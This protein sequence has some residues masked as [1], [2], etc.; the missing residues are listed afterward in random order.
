MSRKS[1]K[2]SIETYSNTG[3]PFGGHLLFY[4][5]ADFYG[6]SEN[7]FNFTHEETHICSVSITSP[8]ARSTITINDSPDPNAV[9]S[10]SLRNRPVGVNGPGGNNNVFYTSEA[11]VYLDE[12]KLPLV[13]S[14]FDPNNPKVAY[15]DTPLIGDFIGPGFNNGQ[16]AIYK[17]RFVRVALSP[18]SYGSWA[19]GA[20]TLPNGRCAVTVKSLFVKDDSRPSYPTDTYLRLQKLGPDGKYI[21]VVPRNALKLGNAVDSEGFCVYVLD[22]LDPD[23]YYSVHVSDITPY[24]NDSSAVRNYKV[25]IKESFASGDT[26]SIFFWANN[27]LDYAVR[28]TTFWTPAPNTSDEDVRF[29]HESCFAGTL[30]GFKNAHKYD[31]K[32]NVLNGDTYYQDNSNAG[33][34]FI[35]HYKSLLRNDNTWLTLVSKGSYVLRDDHEVKDNYGNNIVLTNGNTS[36]FQLNA[37]EN[38]LYNATFAS[39]TTA[40][41]NIYRRINQFPLGIVPNQRIVD[42]FKEFDQMWPARPAYLNTNDS[43]KVTWGKLETIFIN[44]SPFLNPDNLAV[45]YWNRRAI[46]SYPGT[47]ANDINY[48]N[49]APEFIPGPSLAFLKNALLASK[50]KNTMARAVFFSSDIKLTFNGLYD[51]VRAKFAQLA[52][53]ADPSASESLINTTYDK[54]FKAFNYADAEGYF[55]QI[56][57]LVEW[58]KENDIKNVFFFTG[59]PHVS[60]VSYMDRKYNIDSCCCS[61]IA[62]YRASGFPLMFYGNK[63][64]DEVILTVARNSYAD[65]TFSPKNKNMNIKFRYADEIRGETNISLIPN[66][67]P[68]HKCHGLLRPIDLLLGDD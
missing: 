45:E 62:T 3:A 35:R 17:C 4:N 50:N 8:L 52:R 19:G 36:E 41:F 29:M 47:S 13:I 66:H 21:D 48:L 24:T 57:E 22:D 18:T 63:D 46:V 53:I 1:E 34:D 56:L 7:R 65:V 10:D 5:V 67:K 68:H 60:H 14:E 28:T 39:S 27:G 25:A 64:L 32:F 33:P 49:Q 61:S 23:T 44:S 20:Y 31:H 43:W 9:F 51:Q 15:T 55:E 2:N 16:T 58:I 40:P 59:D 54:L 12:Q 26:S 38:A 42:A 6:T 37:A 11:W 30:D